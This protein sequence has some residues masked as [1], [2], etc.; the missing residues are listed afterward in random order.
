VIDYAAI[1]RTARYLARRLPRGATIDA[2]DLAHDS[3]LSALGGR[4]SRKGPMQDALRRQGWLRNHRGSAS[5]RIEF[6]ERRAGA[7]PEKEWSAAIDV[8]RLLARLTA[9]QRQAVEL[10]YLAGMRESEMVIILEIGTQAVR[11]RIHE[12]LKNLRGMI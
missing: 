6:M 2:N 9:K 3:A 11:Q 10:H 8:R 5:F 12:G 1:E 4:Q 7:N